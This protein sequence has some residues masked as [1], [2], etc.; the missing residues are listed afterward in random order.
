MIAYDGQPMAVNEEVCPDWTYVGASAPMI[1]TVKQITAEIAR[2]RQFGLILDVPKE[3]SPS[4]RHVFTN[5]TKK[6]LLADV[7]DWFNECPG[8]S[9]AAY[10]K[11][12]TAAVSPL[13]RG[14]T[15][16]LCFYRIH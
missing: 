11:C 1:P 8:P 2:E 3:A 16:H 12:L 14:Q 4:G 9:T 6:G 5:L 13:N 10:I 7:I 15:G